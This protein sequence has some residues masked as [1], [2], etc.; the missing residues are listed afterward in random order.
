MILAECSLRPEP[1]LICRKPASFSVR[2]AVPL[3]VESDFMGEPVIQT[4]RRYRDDHCD[5]SFS[6]LVQVSSCPS[7][8]PVTAT[9]C[10]S[11]TCSALAPSITVAQ[12]LDHHD[13]QARIVLPFHTSSPSLLHHH[14]ATPS[15]RPTA[16]KPLCSL[17]VLVDAALLP[18]RSPLRQHTWISHASVQLHRTP[19]F[20]L[21]L[22]YF[23]T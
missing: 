22:P 21:F 10:A 9:S 11:W 8:L 20:C 12:L 3:L 7:F 14:Q 1:E 16:S 5:N 4:M 6:K 17:P 19:L 23:T 15:L 2:C 18:T 13:R